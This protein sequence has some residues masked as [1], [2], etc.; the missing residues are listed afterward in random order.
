MEA[1]LLERPRPAEVENRR[2]ATGAEERFRRLLTESEWRALPEATRRRFSLKVKGGESLLF[3]GVTTQLKMSA[4]GRMLC[5]MARIIGAPLPLDMRSEAR[6]AIVA[7][8]EHPS[9]NGQVWTR[10]YAR[11][12]GFPQTVNSVKTFGGPTGLEEHVGGGVSMS[13]LL[14]VERGVLLFR[15]ADYFLG[16]FG[17]RMRIPKWL[18]PGVMVIGHE[19]RGHGCF[20]FT[21]T[22]THPLFGVLVEQTTLFSDMEE[23]RND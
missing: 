2:E 4:F 7:V 21:L 23:A 12:A 9:G 13:L 18:A 11:G 16:A 17:R 22:L 1:P 14:S 10:L 3:Q 8:T 20:A 5:E 19:D 15:S 6:P